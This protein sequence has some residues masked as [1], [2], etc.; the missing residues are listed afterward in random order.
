[1]AAFMSRL[2]VEQAAVMLEVVE[3]TTKH[4]SE[5]EHPR[6]ESA[7]EEAAQQ[8]SSPGQTVD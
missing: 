2:T 8:E 4:L 3:A 5:H 6:V 7:N 1:M